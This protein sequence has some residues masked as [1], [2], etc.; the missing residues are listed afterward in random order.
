MCLSSA[1]SCK[2]NRINLEYYELSHN[3]AK[4]ELVNISKES[5]YYNIEVI[6][7]LEEDMH[8]EVLRKIA[9]MDFYV[10]FGG[11]QPLEGKG[12]IIY[13]DTFKLTITPRVMCKEY[14]EDTSDKLSSGEFWYDISA[15]EDFCKLLEELS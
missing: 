14:L 4:I 12:I 2:D 5:D 9:S 7:T 8:Q 11:P 3:V 1:V 13:D 10:M 6:K 15:D